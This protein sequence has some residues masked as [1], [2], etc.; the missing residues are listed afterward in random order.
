MDTGLKVA[1]ASWG[2]HFYE[3]LTLGLPLIGAQIAQLAINTTD[4]IV[5]GHVGTVELAAIVIASQYFFTVFILGTG[6]SNA[7][8]SMVAQA[9]GRGDT[10]NV[11]RSIRMG[12]WASLAYAVLTLPL[13]YY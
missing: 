12:L 6:F 9:V 7:V 2:R 8:I 11:R 4:V 1:E 10:R 5:V 13:F 3:T